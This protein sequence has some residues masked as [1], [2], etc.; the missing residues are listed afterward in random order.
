[1]RKLSYQAV[2]DV[3]LSNDALIGS[4][5]E[6]HGMLTGMLCVNA[7]AEQEQWLLL[8]F[9]EA[10][11]GLTAEELGVM[12]ELY[13]DTR[14]CLVGV[15]FSFQLFLP[16]DDFLLS[17]RALALSEWCQGFL[18]GVGYSA[19]GR[20]WPGESAEVLRDLADISQLDSNASGDADEEAFMEI[21]EFVRVGVQL[22]HGD[23]QQ[24][25]PISRRLH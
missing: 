12:R 17:E 22:I 24:P 15:D 4:S 5:A 16:D 19:G 1:M 2:Q 8:V 13:D 21:S 7:A 25:A 20:E 10:H 23:L 6:A 9:G 11:D 14:K 3:V 18:Y